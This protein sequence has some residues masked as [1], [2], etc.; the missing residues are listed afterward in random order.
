MSFIDLSK[1]EDKHNANLSHQDFDTIPPTEYD[2]DLSKTLN[3]DL[4]QTMDIEVAFSKLSP[5][6]FEVIEVLFTHREKVQALA[7]RLGV[8]RQTITNRKN[9][10]LSI[11][12][13]ELNSDI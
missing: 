4:D 10:A 13:S 12:H 8:T 5:D 1:N 11:L 6:L 3:V 2:I 7:D 9:A